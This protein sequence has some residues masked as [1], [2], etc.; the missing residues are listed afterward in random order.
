MHPVADF[1][2]PAVERWY[3]NRYCYRPE[4]P[5]P[6]VKR[7]AKRLVTEKGLAKL[8]RR[9]AAQSP[10]QWEWEVL[11]E[12]LLWPL[13]YSKK[14]ALKHRRLYREARK[15]IKQAREFK[16]LLAV[17]SPYMGTFSIL[18]YYRMKRT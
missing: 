2:P 10:T 11:F 16:S 4:A 9:L 18:Y 5:D 13:E 12:T 3:R 17:I 6:T 1:V 8:Y 7:A 15:A 14:E